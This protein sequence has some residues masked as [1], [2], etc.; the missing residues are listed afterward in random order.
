MRPQAELTSRIACDFAHRVK[1]VLRMPRFTILEHDHP[2]L[3]WDL[4]LE[5]GDTLK[6][7]R[8]AQPPGPNTHRIEATEIADHRLLYLDYEGPVSGERGV[9]KRWD[10]GV[11]LEESDSTPDCRR[12]RFAGKRLHALVRL[13]RVLGAKWHWEIVT[14]A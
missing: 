4:L 12:F 13:T 2:A 8:L 11:F 10:G 7:W 3:H 1:G 14:V 5:S 9:V 6:T